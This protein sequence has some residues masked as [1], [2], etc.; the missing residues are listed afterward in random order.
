M[1]ATSWPR[2]T[3]GS[4]CQSDDLK[5][6]NKERQTQWA[7][8]R[9]DGTVP[10]PPDTRPQPA[11]KTAAQ[12]DAE[13]TAPGE[14]PA[15][16]AEFTH[17]GTRIYQVNIKRGDAVAAMWGVESAENK[18]KREA[19]ERTIGGDSLHET[20]DAAIKAAEREAKSNAQSEA[21]R[22]ERE[23]TAQKEKAAKEAK[24]AD[25]INGF[26]EGMAPNTAALAAKA[27]EK[28]VRFKGEVASIRSFIDK[29][30]EAGTLEVS[31]TQEP[32]I[33]PMS[34]TAYNRADNKAQDEHERRMKEAGNKTVYWVNDI[35]LG[36]IA[37][38]Y[39][40]HMLELEAKPADAANPKPTDSA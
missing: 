3:R 31:T 21:Y 30:H 13:K 29:W 27:L 6:A 10:P 25:T 11:P 14:P 36:K 7:K 24:A 12:K 39:A 23:E 4:C 26:T 18:A 32:R 8:V 35:D 22:K 17:N 1:K 16:P 2:E 9:K 38:D 34:R 15:K 37:H 40:Q 5:I 19:G 33:K 20:R 28:E